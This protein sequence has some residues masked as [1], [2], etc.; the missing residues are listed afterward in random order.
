M[1]DQTGEGGH[2]DGQDSSR[3]VQDSLGR[4]EKKLQ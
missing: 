4:S 1:G 2:G 3:E